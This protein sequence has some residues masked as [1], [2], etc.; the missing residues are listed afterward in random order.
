VSEDDGIPGAK[1]FPGGQWEDRGAAP[2]SLDFRDPLFVR[3]ISV[4]SEAC[5]MD[6]ISIDALF[7]AR[8]RRRDDRTADRA[9]TP[10]LIR[11]EWWLLSHRVHRVGGREATT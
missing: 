6:G 9:V 10:G 2:S 3:R 1:R 4:H 5:H 11:P 8:A 7:I